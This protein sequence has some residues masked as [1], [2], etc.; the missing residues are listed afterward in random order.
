M[1]AVAEK[2]KKL[3]GNSA[4]LLPRPP[5]PA[6]RKPVVAPLTPAPPPKPSLPKKRATHGRSVRPA[7]T[8]S[9]DQRTDVTCSFQTAESQNQDD[10][11]PLSDPAES[12]SLC[13]KQLNSDDWMTKVKGLRCIPAL[14]QHH[15]D[16]LMPKLH[17]VCLVVIEEVKNLRPSVAC[18]AMDTIRCLYVHLQKGM[19][20][21]ANWTGQALLLK[22]SQACGNAFL[23]QQ[24]SEA[25]EALV[26]N[27]SP[28]RVLPV[29]LN[30]GQSHLSPAVRASTARLLH[31]LADRLGATKVLT[32]RQSFTQRFLTAVS[33]M[34]LDAAA[35]V[36][37]HGR[38]I[39]QKLALHRD[40]MK[41]WQKN[42]AEK[43]RHSLE[44]V[45]RNV[46]KN[47]KIHI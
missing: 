23:Q 22:I 13:F 17:E 11:Q 4:A 19:D 12:L 36:R 40:F 10:L 6:T 14:A 27:C 16:T 1:E 35:E 24:A 15:P 47:I 20:T 41:L 5:A 34:S 39:L 38:A 32:A 46:V 31:L 30:T 28:G 33:K 43:D 7:K 25:L 26:Q 21:E 18:A 8:V 44:K 9:R 2:V 37:P 29:L 45:L 42:V 3:Q